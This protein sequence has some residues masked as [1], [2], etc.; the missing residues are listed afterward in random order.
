M[1]KRGCGSNIHGV[2]EEI[3]PHSFLKSTW[4]YRRSFKERMRYALSE[5]VVCSAVDICII[6]LGP[7]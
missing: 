1:R 4:E 2:G 3:L 5:N 7:H 6:G